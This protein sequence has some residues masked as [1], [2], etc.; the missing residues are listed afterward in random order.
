MKIIE[1]LRNDVVK[2]QNERKF[3]HK[4]YQEEC[5]HSKDLQK[6]NN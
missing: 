3:F 5:V 4:K 2:F 1:K 6:T